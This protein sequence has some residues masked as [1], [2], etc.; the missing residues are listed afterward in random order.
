[1]LRS[2]TEMGLPMDRVDL[3][4]SPSPEATTN[5]VHLYVR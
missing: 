2:L 3:S 1:V 4:Y 5:E